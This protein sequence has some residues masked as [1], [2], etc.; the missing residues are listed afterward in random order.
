[1]T[2]EWGKER[3]GGARPNSGGKREGAGRPALGHVRTWVRLPSDVIAAAAE[4]ARALTQ[5]ERRPVAVQEVYRRVLAGELP[6]LEAPG[7]G[8][9]RKTPIDLQPE[10]LER[11]RATAAERGLSQAGAVDFLLRGAHL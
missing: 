10:Q 7:T 8:P 1:M 6:P 5:A 11:L 3:R 2:R 4:R 9:Q